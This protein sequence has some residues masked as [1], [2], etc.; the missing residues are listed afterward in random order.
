[1]QKNVYIAGLV[2]IVLAVGFA[3]V[4]GKGPSLGAVASPD[5]ISPYF[6][7]GGVRQWAAH[8]DSLKSA[9][10]TVCAIQSPAATSTL[11]FGSIKLLTSST[12]AT[13]VTLAKA[14]TAFATTT[15]LG[16]YSVGANAQATLVASSSP[17]SGNTALVFSPNT[18]FVVGMAG[19]VGTFSPAGTCEAVWVEN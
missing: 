16:S 2:A 4:G 12:T 19:G 11:R 6:S 13:T 17:T 10:T 18:F 7:F 15:D 5:L 8:T 3:L 14:S 1:M 9:T